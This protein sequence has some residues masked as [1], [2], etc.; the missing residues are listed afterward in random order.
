LLLDSCVWLGVR[1]ALIEAGH[2]VVWVGDWSGDPGDD[3]IMAI[4]LAERR[5]LVTLD[6]DFGELAIVR[7]MEHW[8]IVRLVEQSIRHQ[9]RLALAVVNEYEKELAAG[10]IVTVERNRVRVRRGG[11]AG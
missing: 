3:A 5:I 2:D 1:D 8:G 10:A 9:G 7:G 11:R 4:A 6:K